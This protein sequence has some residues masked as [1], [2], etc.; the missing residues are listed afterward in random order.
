M[1]DPD[2]YNESKLVSLLTEDSEYAFQ[3]IYD[4]HRNKIYKT[5]IRFLKS[6]TTAQEVVQD[7]FMKLWVSRRTINPSQ[8]IGAWLHTLA[9]NNIINRLKKLSNEWKAMHALPHITS[10]NTNATE[11]TVQDSEY[12]AILNTAI[13]ALTEQQKKVY[14]LSRN[15]NLTYIQ[16]GEKLTLSP[17]TVKTHISRALLFIRQAFAAKGIKI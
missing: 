4:L 9:K 13:N 7:V 1:L 11:N 8:P 17:L 5:A 10:D 12:N 2:K 3:I 6:P 16:I 15:E 14:L